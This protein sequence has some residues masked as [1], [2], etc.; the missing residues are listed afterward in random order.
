[1]FKSLKE[2]AGCLIPMVLY[3]CFIA[4]LFF[5]SNKGSGQDET[6]ET[7]DVEHYEPKW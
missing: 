2:Y 3:I 4:Y 5:T 6:D 1:M 7:F